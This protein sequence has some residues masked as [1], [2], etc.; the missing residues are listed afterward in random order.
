MLVE[1]K[2][3]MKIVETGIAIIVETDLMKHKTG[4]SNTNRLFILKV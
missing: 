3:N 1:N 4:M 2:C